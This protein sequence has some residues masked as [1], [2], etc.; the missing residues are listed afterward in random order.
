[1]WRMGFASVGDLAACADAEQ[2]GDRL[3]N[4]DEHSLLVKGLAGR[5]SESL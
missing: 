5:F 1:M 3:E 4:G 2:Q